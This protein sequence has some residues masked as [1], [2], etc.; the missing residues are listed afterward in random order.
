MNWEE[1]Y[2][3]LPGILNALTASP[4][5][6]VRN[7]TEAEVG[8]IFGERETPGLYVFWL[9]KTGK[10][11]YVGRTKNIQRQVGSQHRLLANTLTSLTVTLLRDPPLKLNG[12][13]AAREYLFDNYEA[14]F[15][16]VPDFLVRA[17]AELYVHIQLG[18]KYNSFDE[19]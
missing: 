15:V 2:R 12:Q 17:A 19:R 9:A 5:Y 13:R 11:D 10:A 16:K 8:K 3:Q 6:P 14:S 7:L 18:T 1:I 4:R